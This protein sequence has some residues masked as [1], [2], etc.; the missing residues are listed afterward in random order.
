[1]TRKPCTT[2]CLYGSEGRCSLE[3]ILGERGPNCPHYEEGFI[4]SRGRI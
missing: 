3:H 1:M 2:R 4:L